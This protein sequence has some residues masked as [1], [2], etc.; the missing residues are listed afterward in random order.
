[1]S[2]HSLDSILYMHRYLDR[3]IYILGMLNIHGTAKI[4]FNNWKSKTCLIIK[5]I[6]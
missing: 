2:I 5:I 1:M 6:V 4:N 3:T